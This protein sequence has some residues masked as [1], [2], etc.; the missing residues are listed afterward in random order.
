MTKPDFNDVIS[1][2]SSTAPGAA[3]EPAPRTR[4]Y[5]VASGASL[6]KIAEREYGSANEWRRIY[7]ANRDSIKNPDLIDPGQTLRIP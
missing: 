2:S 1:G 3:R 5:T 4:T 6:S 7:E